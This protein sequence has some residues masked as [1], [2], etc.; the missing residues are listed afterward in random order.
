MNILLK[1]FPKILRKEIKTLKTKK[2]LV[3]GTDFLLPP[4]LQGFLWVSQPGKQQVEIALPRFTPH[5]L[6]QSCL[7]GPLFLWL[8]SELKASLPWLTSITVAFTFQWANSSPTLAHFFPITFLEPKQ[9]TTWALPVASSTQS[10]LF[11][12]PSFNKNTLS[13]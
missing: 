11:H 9:S 10:P 13:K 6:P 8:S 2:D 3:W 5:P 7:Q 12:C 4:K 1:P